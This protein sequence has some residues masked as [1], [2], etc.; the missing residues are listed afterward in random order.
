MRNGKFFVLKKTVC[1]FL[2]AATLCFSA[3][4]DNKKDESSADLMKEENFQYP[5]KTDKTLKY[6]YVD[7]TAGQENKAETPHSKAV[8]EATGIKLEWIPVSASIATE[9]FNLMLASGN[10]PDIVKY[11]W[12][13][14][15]GGA[16]SAV[17]A[18]QILKLNDY[19]RDYMPNLKKYLSDNPAADKQ[20]KNDNGNYCFVPA[21]RGDPQLLTYM[22]PIVRKDWLDELGLD[23][24]ETIDDWKIML[25]AFRDKKGASVGLA[26]GGI[27]RW[28][29]NAKSTNEKYDL[30]GTKYPVANKK[31]LIEQSKLQSYAEYIGGLGVQLWDAYSQSLAFSNQKDA[32]ERWRDTKAAEYLMPP[33]TMMSEESGRTSKLLILRIKNIIRPPTAPQMRRLCYMVR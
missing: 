8:Y 27:G 11:D 22:G 17:D 21:Y 24:A 30:I 31:E 3:G 26:G 2:A 12:T 14:L 13:S 19:I 1:F 23:V 16:Q 15:P 10:V 4:C 32:I 29:V 7:N 28:L 25:K 6:W 9:Q 20:A 5:V 33:V 18:G